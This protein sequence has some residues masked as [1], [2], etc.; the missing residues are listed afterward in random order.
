MENNIVIREAILEDAPVITQILSAAFKEF[1][2]NYTP[3]AFAA[4]VV[5]TEK[6]RERINKGVVWIASLKNNPIGTV[7]GQILNHT[8]YIKGMGVLPEAR[9]M[10]IGY[11]L[12]RTIEA[13][14]RKNNCRELLLNTTPY[15][16]QAIRL[17]ERFGFE[18]INEP[19][20]DLFQTPLYNMKKQ[21]S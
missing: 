18:I 16:K 12:L 10:K 19:P 2:T 15:L 13:Y 8:F 4:T 3:G 7:S 14:A 9:G 20:Y 21:L 11:Q 17:Y 6:A 5:S 1:K